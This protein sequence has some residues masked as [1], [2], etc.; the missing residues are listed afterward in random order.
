VKQKK[1]NSG[2]LVCRDFGYSDGLIP[3]GELAGKGLKNHG[4]TW[5]DV[6]KVKRGVVHLI[7]ALSRVYLRPRMSDLWNRNS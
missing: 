1:V 7:S 3:G 2:G 6:Q 5:A 4:R